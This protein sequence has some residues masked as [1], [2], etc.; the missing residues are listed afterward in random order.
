MAE[1]TDEISGIHKDMAKIQQ[2]Y[3]E[4]A[5]MVTDQ[6]EELDQI[7]ATIDTTGDNTK[8]AREEVEQS[9]EFQR[10]Q[11]KI[12]SCLMIAG[13]IGWQVGWE[14]GFPLCVGVGRGVSWGT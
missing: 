9:D 11:T 14:F 4:V 8:Q 5:T 13:G 6:G 1:R 3:N 10:R 2:M 12:Y 7:V